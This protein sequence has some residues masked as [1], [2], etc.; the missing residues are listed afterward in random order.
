ML[1]LGFAAFSSAIGYLAILLIQRA[2]FF[3]S[4]GRFDVPILTAAEIAVLVGYHL[5]VALV[6]LNALTR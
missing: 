3:V 5:V 6:C 2:S 1:T 4:V